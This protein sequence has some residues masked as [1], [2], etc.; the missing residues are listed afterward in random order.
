[1]SSVDRQLKTIP[2][3]G[4]YYINLASLDRKIFNYNPAATNP[5]FTAANWATPGNASYQVDISANGA[6]VLRDLGKTVVSS[7][8]TFRK[9]QLV[10][11]SLSSGTT[12][13]APVGSQNAA[14]ANPVVGE[15]YFTGYIEVIGT[16]G[17]GLTGGVGAIQNIAP[18]ARMG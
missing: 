11:S 16:Y 9:V 17:R 6:V 5:V 3:E 1:M 14:T 18:V 8:R 12:I 7:L 15:E 4:A 13:G 2:S 10:T